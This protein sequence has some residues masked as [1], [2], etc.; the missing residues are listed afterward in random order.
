MLKICDSEIVRSLSLIIK[1]CIRCTIFPNISKK[2]NL[3]P[4][5]KKGNKKIIKS[6]RPIS[7]YQF[8]GRYLKGLFLIRY[9]SFL[10]K[11]NYFSQINLVS[12]QL[13]SI[14]QSIYKGFDHNSSPEV[15]SNFLDISRAF[16]RVWHIELLYKLETVGI[17]GDLLNL[18]QSF[19]SNQYQKIVLT[20]LR[21]RLAIRQSWSPTRLNAGSSTI[22]GLH[23]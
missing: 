1:N 17:S 23:K 14:V 8:V 10:A 18:F 19:L 9:L 3:A 16:D 12:D 5:H 6:Y 21:I 22:F 4:V 7:N 20:W 15:C 11:A 13:L 2:S